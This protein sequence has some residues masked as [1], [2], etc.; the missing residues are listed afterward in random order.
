MICETKRKTQDE[1]KAERTLRL[2]RS[3]KKTRVQKETPKKH[4]K[5]RTYSRLSENEECD[6]ATKH[7]PKFIH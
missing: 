7:K 2:F 5:S 4:I 1:E 6:N 3:S